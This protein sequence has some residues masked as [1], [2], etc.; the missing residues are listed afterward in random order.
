M[1]IFWAP[2]AMDMCRLYSI[3]L[4]FQPL[5]CCVIDQIADAPS[6]HA[7]STVLEDAAHLQIICKR[8]TTYVTRYKSRHFW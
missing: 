6:L 4:A 3:R 5:K 7:C 1:K 2:W 8:L